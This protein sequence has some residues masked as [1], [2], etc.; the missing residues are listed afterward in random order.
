MRVHRRSK[1]PRGQ[2]ARSVV[3]GLIFGIF[4]SACSD[5]SLLTQPRVRLDPAD[6][7]EAVA[8]G[9]TP[10]GRFVLPT[11]VVNP[12]G[13]LSEAQAKSIATRYVKDV[14]RSR[15]SEWTAE[16]GAAIQPKELNPCDRALYAANPYTSLNGANLSEITIRTFDAHWVIPMCGQAHQLQI[17]VS[18]SALAT[19]LTANL[20]STKPLPWER[21][22]VMSFGVPAGAAGSMYSPEGVAR[23]AFTAGGKRV[24]SIPELIMTPMPKAPVIVRW[25]L[26]LEA[27]ITVTGEHSAVTR[28]RSTV[29]VGFG[30]TYKSAGLLDSDPKAE[31]P[32]VS[33]IDPVTNASFTVVLAPHAPNGVEIVTRRNPRAT[34]QSVRTLRGWLSVLPP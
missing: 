13:Q 7:T 11:S 15:L 6:V 25:R 27:P 9:L 23:Y 5:T 2:F 12:P 20:G 21:S 17:V 10:D 30:D 4:P 1:P 8:A 26:D 16:H 32:N 3:F 22:N 33:W 28:D 34:H 24:N 14:A 31:Q 19:E 29:L 18:F